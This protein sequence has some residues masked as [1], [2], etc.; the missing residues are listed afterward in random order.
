[1][2]QECTQ[3]R[4]LRKSLGGPEKSRQSNLAVFTVEGKFDAKYA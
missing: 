1:M 4:D 3:T 2:I